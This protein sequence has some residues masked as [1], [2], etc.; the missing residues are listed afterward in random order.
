MELPAF[1]CL[2]RNDEGHERTPPKIHGVYEIGW[3]LRLP[4]NLSQ[5]TSVKIAALSRQIGH[6][7]GDR[8]VSRARHLNIATAKVS[9]L[10]EGLLSLAFVGN[11][12]TFTKLMRLHVYQPTSSDSNKNAMNTR[13]VVTDRKQQGSSN[14]GGLSSGCSKLRMKLEIF[15]ISN[16]NYFHIVVQMLF[17]PRDHESEINDDFGDN[18]EPTMDT[19]ELLFLAES[20]GSPNHDNQSSQRRRSNGSSAE[21]PPPL[22]EGAFVELTVGGELF[23]VNVLAEDKPGHKEEGVRQ[24]QRLGVRHRVIVK[25]SKKDPSQAKAK[26]GQEVKDKDKNASGWLRHFPPLRRVVTDDSG[27]GRSPPAR[28][29]KTERAEEEPPSSEADDSLDSVSIQSLPTISTLGR[30]PPPPPPLPP[31]E[32]TVCLQSWRVKSISSQGTRTSTSSQER[33]SNVRGSEATLVVHGM[34]D[35]RVSRG[36]LLNF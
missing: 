13:I 19:V 3:P 35:T 18:G 25:V 11:S 7:C 12:K 20:R 30:G 23:V 5:P 26:G 21:S 14:N 6:G 16:S 22:G 15:P 31:Q 1:Y 36:V 10:D 34:E 27:D 4:K 17:Y 24:N 2:S 32:Y 33:V 9:C 28:K 29:R 8:L